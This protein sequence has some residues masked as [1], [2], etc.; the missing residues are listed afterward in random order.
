M[1]KTFLG[2][3]LVLLVLLISFSFYFSRS[4]G[5]LIK[6]EINHFIAKIPDTSFQSEKI[7]FAFPFGINIHNVLFKY[8]KSQVTVK[9]VTLNVNLIK[10]IKTQNPL[11]SISETSL[12]EAE[13]ILKKIPS[14]PGFKAPGLPLSSHRFIWRN[15]K[16]ITGNLTFTSDSGEI[17]SDTRMLSVNANLEINPLTARVKFYS[18]FSEKNWRLD[19]FS[20][21]QKSKVTSN[22]ELKGAYDKDFFESAGNVVLQAK[23]S[24]FV[25]TGSGNFK[26][27]G[28]SA[29]PEITIDI[30]DVSYNFT[31]NV[32][33]GKLKITLN[34]NKFS[35]EELSISSAT[36][37]LFAKG[38]IQDNNLSFSSTIR[39]LELNNFVKGLTGKINSRITISGTFKNPD[40]ISKTTFEKIEIIPLDFSIHKGE[41]F[42]SSKNNKILFNLKSAEQVILVEATLQGIKKPPEAYGN[43]QIK[44]KSDLTGTF[45]LQ[46]DEFRLA[47]VRSHYE[48]KESLFFNAAFKKQNKDR[49]FYKLVAKLKQFNVSKKIYVTGDFE[50]TG[51]TFQKDEFSADGILKGRNIQING[52]PQSDLKMQVSITKNILNSEIS[53]GRTLSGEIKMDLNDK[54]ASFK[55]SGEKLSYRKGVLSFRTKGK[56]YSGKIKLDG[57]LIVAEKEKGTFSADFENPGQPVINAVISIPYLS[58]KTLNGFLSQNNDFKLPVS[59]IVNL[60]VNIAGKLDNPSI[61][62][63]AQSTDLMSYDGKILPENWSGFILAGNLSGQ[64]KRLSI[65]KCEILSEEQKIEL[66]KGSFFNFSDK[67]KVSLSVDVKVSNLN[68]GIIK[69]FGTLKASGSMLKNGT[70][71]EINLL[72]QNFWL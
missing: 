65:D 3:S 39:S 44:G 72:T 67:D 59:G 49:G 42:L 9:K 5:Y 26:I 17:Y 2:I 34:E 47:N 13:I 37:S 52:T 19:L 57:D 63:T 6:K 58:V 38:S 56:Y 50:M 53:L 12:Y 18:D 46:K 51:N 64:M 55:L 35:L 14:M 30:P 60:G 70:Y 4:A 31:K 66:L 48:G 62:F 41:M 20:Q 45:S 32:Y 36:Q 68:V 1:K 24:D 8:E 33:K 10:L 54:T 43:F 23:T 11:T 27:T 71:A 15:L 7:S 25:L 21:L 28:I 61:S 69:A 22:V 40:F 16:V 29:P